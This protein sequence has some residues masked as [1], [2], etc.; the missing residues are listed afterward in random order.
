MGFIASSSLAAV[1]SIDMKFS[2]PNVPRWGVARGGCDARLSRPPPAASLV[3][4]EDTLVALLLQAVVALSVV[5]SLARE[6]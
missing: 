2:P 3:S 1:E 4:A 6:P 5:A